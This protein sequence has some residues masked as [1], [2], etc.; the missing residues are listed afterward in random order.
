M[1]SR[2]TLSS[3]SEGVIEPV[4]IGEILV[5]HVEGA[6]V[7]VIFIPCLDFRILWSAGTGHQ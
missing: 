1:I 5:R 3:L 4:N 2:F 6:E 7:D